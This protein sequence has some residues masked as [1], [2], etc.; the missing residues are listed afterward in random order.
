[1][2]LDGH[3]S[4]A[5]DVWAFGM[6]AWELYASFATGYDKRSLSAPFYDVENHEVNSRSSLIAFQSFCI[7]VFVKKKM[8]ELI[9][10]KQFLGPESSAT[11][12]FNSR[13]NSSLDPGLIHKVIKGSLIK[14]EDISPVQRGY[15]KPTVCFRL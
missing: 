2:I 3:Y 4:F 6:L 15:G 9:I 12:K 8:F 10:T 5:S 14:R 7:F 1:M 13:L 11:R